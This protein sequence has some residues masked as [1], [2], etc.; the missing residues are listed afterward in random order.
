MKAWGESLGA[1]ADDMLLLADG[2]N[3]FTKARSEPQGHIGMS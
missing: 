3:E 1:S 2:N